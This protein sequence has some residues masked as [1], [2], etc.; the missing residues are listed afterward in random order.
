MAWVAAVEHMCRVRKLG[1]LMNT[2][3]AA[4]LEVADTSGLF[5]SG[6]ASEPA[7]MQC[8]RSYL[9][10]ATATAITLH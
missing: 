7:N 9:S 6:S 2:T 4:S 10:D 1:F 3:P 5:T 8:C